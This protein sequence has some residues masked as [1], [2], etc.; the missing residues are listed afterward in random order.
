[1]VTGLLARVGRISLGTPTKSS[2][3]VPANGCKASGSGLNSLILETPIDLMRLMA[4][5]GGGR[6]VPTRP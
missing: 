5:E 2:I 4:S 3:P 1:M 6:F